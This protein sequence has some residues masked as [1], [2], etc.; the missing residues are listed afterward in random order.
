MD[1]DAETGPKHTELQTRSTLHN[2]PKA[3]LLEHS[4]GAGWNSNS[5]KK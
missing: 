5:G 2:Q 1:L 3:G 4:L